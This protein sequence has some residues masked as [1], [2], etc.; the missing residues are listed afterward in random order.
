MNSGWCVKN[1]EF[2]KKGDGLTLLLEVGYGEA[3]ESGSF[4]I[5]LEIPPDVN[6]LRFGKEQHILWTRKPAV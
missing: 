5:P 3:G 4:A 2:V 6:V 1:Y